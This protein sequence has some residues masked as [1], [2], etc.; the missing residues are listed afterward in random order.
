[1]NI[2]FF[3]AT[4]EWSGGANRLFLCCRELI[5]R[6]H[7]IV[8]CTLPGNEMS[9]R[10]A[11][12]GIPYFNLDPRSDIN[13]LMLPEIIRKIREHRIDILDIH[14][15][16][17]YWL[18]ALAAKVAGRP[19][20]ITRNVPFRKKGIKRSLNR[21]LY[22][23]LADRVVAISDRIRR[24]LIED[25][26]LDD[27]TVEVI[28]DGLDTS[29]FEMPSPSGD[30]SGVTVGVLSRLVF[31]KGLECLVDAM[32]GI[33]REIP[34]VR[35]VIAGTGPLE[36]NLRRRVAE[37]NLG[38]KVVFTGFRS[39]IPRLLSELDITVVPSPQEGMSMSALESMAAGRPVVATSGGGLIDIIRNNETG[40]IV[41]PDD[42]VA[43]AS[44]VITL[45]QSDYRTVGMKARL[46]VKEK[47]ELQGTIDRFES[48][49]SS[50][51]GRRR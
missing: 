48:L 15:P 39:D 14:S 5:R 32:P 7:R 4:R 29:R 38:E 21:L 24:E 8:V 27:R 2:M 25:Y 13:L 50:L 40:V 35:F 30:L 28:Y 17:F 43:L 37:L 19:V 11:Q 16:K 18:G 49:I 36:E 1:M 46:I 20:I 26:R 6:G 47:F 34:A 45:L 22:A 9:G 3:D 23:R 10:L 42:P 31:G 41:E 12:E 51:A 44:G 33:V